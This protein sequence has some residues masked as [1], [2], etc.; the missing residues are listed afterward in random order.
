M[1]DTILGALI[2]IGGV[3]VG[4]ILAFVLQFI[5][6]KIN[7]K[8]ENRRSTYQLKIDTYA[9]A[10]RYIALYCTGSQDGKETER[11][12]DIVIQQDELYNKFH[13]IFS[14]IADKDTIEKYNELRAE[15]SS[16]KIKHADAYKRV[17][18]LLNFNINDE[19]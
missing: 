3:L 17:V 14:I 9:D 5:L 2:G 11:F 1:S 15:A 12:T 4:G 18:Q 19:I 8:K 6:D 13:P 10:I 16:G 7:C